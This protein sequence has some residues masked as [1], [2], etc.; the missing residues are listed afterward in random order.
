[1][2][3]VTIKQFLSAVALIVLLIVGLRYL[4]VQRIDNNQSGALTTAA[5]S[6]PT[7][8][9]TTH[10]RWI[11][12]S[13][14]N[15]LPQDALV[16][17]GESLSSA[18]RDSSLRN[19]VQPFVDGYSELLP[20]VLE[21]ISGPDRTPHHNVVDY[22][23]AGSPQ[24]AWVG[25]LRGGRICISTDDQHHAKV[26]LL[27]DDPKLAYHQNY[28][29]IRHCLA[30]LL[31]HAQGELEVD[32][33]AY[34]N[35]YLAS[36][37]RINTIPYSL[38]ATS[39][40]SDKTDLDLEGLADFFAQGPELR[41]AAVNK[42]TGLTLYGCASGKQ[43]L[44]GK[45]VELA[46]LAVAYRAVFHAG[47]NE[48]FI[49]LDPHKDPTKVTVNFGGFLE[50]TRMGSVVLEADK[51]FKTITSGLDP[52]TFLDRRAYTRT[53][54]PS[55]LSSAERDLLNGD[56]A[57]TGKWIGTRFWYYPD[58]IGVDS[59]LGYEYA[60]ITN[61]RFTADAER[62]REDF[63]SPEEFKQKKNETLLP[64]IRDNI[65]DLNRNYIEYAR[66]FPE[67]AELQQVARLMGICSWLF[68]AA[69]SYLDSDDL[70]AVQL[71]ACNTESERTQL[72]AATYLTVSEAERHER[73]RV[74]EDSTV[75]FLTPILD[76][77]VAEFF[78]TPANV[79]K[80]LSGTHDKA[81]LERSS[82]TV[83]ANRLFEQYQQRKVREMVDS[84]RA[85]EKLADYAA[86]A[87]Q[88]PKPTSQTKLDEQI[89]LG[90][91]D[92]EQLKTKITRLKR[93]L[94]QDTD[95]DSHN[96]LVDV[97]NQLVGRYELVRQNL[98]ALIDQ[99][100]AMHFRSPFIVE[101]GGGIN[102]EPSKFAIRQQTSS[103]SLIKLKE[104]A[105]VVQP[106]WTR[107][108]DA[109]SWI[110]SKTSARP[111][112]KNRFDPPDISAAAQQVRRLTNS[113]DSDNGSW[114]EAVKLD[115]T[116]SQE[117]SYNAQKQ[118]I[119][120]ARFS[121]GR[122]QDL[123]VGHRDSDGRIIFERS[124]RTNVIPKDF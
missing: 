17:T 100:N 67:I 91:Q 121:S 110:C 15:L 7:R 93:Q 18:L 49:S 47:D 117:K 51:R 5:A 84:K 111:A 34:H 114:S 1:M 4:S 40:D 105:K 14:A 21:M 103:P 73:A 106:Q 95:P 3:R 94:Q 41:G 62:S 57:L 22:F 11:T 56:T 31:R 81:R 36:E 96:S 108:V 28:S 115:G 71:P 123:V 109:E 45:P 75:V 13:Y 8:G 72:L 124:D 87:V 63:A 25:I 59:D 89:E 33:F 122:L 20:S 38:R 26:F 83:E 12:V 42:H 80:Y 74:T 50:N 79:E 64:S 102:L 76:M 32:T 88:P 58:T 92:L 70:L 46:D 112:R 120:I 24:P 107:T 99:H 113:P 39:F 27:G 55:F 35:D 77:T 118:Q 54:V 52:N 23:H 30:M 85:L 65:A 116:R 90:K 44:D 2:P 98:N 101:I 43:T 29:V 119:Q 19:A 86:S 60:V 69:P 53:H 82:W 104:I 37:L 66:T 78:Q 16:R 48:A 68:K 97:H 10:D 61:P 6:E 9:A